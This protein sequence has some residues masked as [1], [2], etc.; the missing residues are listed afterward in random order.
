MGHLAY[1]SLEGLVVPLQ[2]PVGQRIEG[3]S[4][5][6]P[7]VHHANVAS[8]SRESNQA[9]PQLTLSERTDSQTTHR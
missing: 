9:V 5:Y 7:D 8:D 3:S 6:V 1:V 4:Q 2:L